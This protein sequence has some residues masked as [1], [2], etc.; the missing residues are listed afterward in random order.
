M[1]RL[2]TGHVRSLASSHKASRVLQ[3]VLKYGTPAQRAS[4]VAE[5]APELAALAKDAYGT[6][7]VRRLAD[8][9]ERPELLAIAKA[10]KGSACA[11]AR[12]PFG[13][14]VLDALYCRLPARARAA[15]L[16]EFYGPQYALAR[17]GQRAADDGAG[18]GAASAPPRL[19]DVVA[20]MPASTRA[21]AVA[22][23]GARLVPILEKG[24]VSFSYLHRV[25]AEYLAAAG[26]AGAAEAAAS[27]AGPALL[28]MIHTA[29]GARCAA[30][31]LGGAAARERKAALKALKGRVADVARDAHGHVALLAA[32]DCVDDTALL[33]S[34]V[35]NELTPALA[36]HACD[37]HARRLLLQLLAPRCARYLPP[38]VLAALPMQAAP[39]AGGA[40]PKDDADADDDE[41]EDESDSDSEGVGEGRPGVIAVSKK[42]AS[43]RRAQLLAALAA[44]LAAACAAAAPRLLRHPLGCDVIFEAARGGAGGA[45]AAAAGAQAMTTLHAAIAAAAASS[46]PISATGGDGEEAENDAGGGAEVARDSFFATRTLRRLVLADADAEAEAAQAAGPAPGGGASFAAALWKGALKGRG[47]DWATGHG[48]KVLAACCACGDA[49]VAAAAC[50]EAAPLVAPEAPAAWA[51]RHVGAGAPPAVAAPKTTKAAAKAPAA[52]AAKAPAAKAAKPQ[53]ADKAAPKKQ[54][55]K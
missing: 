18:D 48:A 1:S 47:R 50:A 35:L 31:L 34:A 53:A 46:V 5:A 32:L 17:A 20:A 27:V 55:R 13:A 24:L 33:R 3:S 44:P 36:D 9:A 45:F 29:D 52:K 38:D 54:A 51:K 39:P 14:P 21:G 23:I 40:D 22:R 42:P 19:A 11:L 30:A 43:V 2:S 10:L 25:L 49:A 12:H 16:A 6:H 8:S 37:P 28:R 4:L 15:I 26:P 7:L 41:E